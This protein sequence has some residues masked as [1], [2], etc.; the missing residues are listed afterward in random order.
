MFCR[1]AAQEL[2]LLSPRLSQENVRL[3]GIGLEEL[4]VEEFVEKK[5]WAGELYID[6]KKK[7][8]N[9]LGY[10]RFSIWS[11]P[12]LLLSRIARSQAALG[13]ERGVG[14]DLRGD[15]FQNGGLIVVGK[16]GKLLY[17]FVQENPADHAANEDILKALNLSGLMVDKSTDE[18]RPAA[19]SPAAC[20]QDVCSLKPK[21]PPPA[22]D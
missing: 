19:A 6:E 17:S 4:G 12:G 18:Q 2:S 16:G 8:F 1:L 21:S 15:G 3:V 5:F 7:S 10:K 9:D 20:D 11:L 14:G 13:K 22:S